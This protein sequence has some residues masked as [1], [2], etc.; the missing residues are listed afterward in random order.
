[1]DHH[2]KH[3]NDPANWWFGSIYVCSA[4]PRWVVSKKR[5]WAGWTFNYGHRGSFALLAWVAVACVV[6]SSWVISSGQVTFIW[7]AVG[8]SA[9]LAF[10]AVGACATIGR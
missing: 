3:W 5:S 1:M 9:V 10:S 6:P 4:E 2:Q 8:V 7:A